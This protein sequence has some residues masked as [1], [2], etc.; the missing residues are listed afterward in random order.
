MALGT[1]ILPLLWL[2]PLVGALC[3]VPL[4]WVT[5]RWSRAR[6]REHLSRTPTPE[7]RR[8][9]R[10]LPLVVE[11]LAACMAAGFGPVRAADAVG[12]SLD[13]PLADRLRR[14][15]GELRLGGEPGVVWRRLGASPV[16]RELAQCLERCQHS[17]SPGAEPLA[18][19][20]R[21]SRARQTRE[22]TAR[23]R[24]AAVRITVPLGV[25]FLPAFL[26]LGIAPGVIA[27]LGQVL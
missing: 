21:E 17:G 10:Q 8:A 18:R 25:C 11:L 4:G 13:G 14:A 12:R 9:A 16:T 15:A 2:E 7:E 27:L 5:W 22:A 26:V 23:A 24:R 20:A 6:H 19:L 3:G 1:G